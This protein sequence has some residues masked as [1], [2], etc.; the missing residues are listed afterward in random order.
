M[1]SANACP[2]ARQ[3]DSRRQS[4]AEHDR[5][6][7]HDG[8]VHLGNDEGDEGAALAS[9]VSHEPSGRQHRHR[10]GGGSKQ[11]PHSKHRQQR[12]TG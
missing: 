4:P 11:E 10:A 6:G 3:G 12:A 7:N 8:R 9:P 1:A 5:G 2:G